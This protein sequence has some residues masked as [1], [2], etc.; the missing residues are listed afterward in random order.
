MHPIDADVSRPPIRLRPPPLAN[1]YLSGPRRLKSHSAFPIVTTLSQ[2]IQMRPRHF[3]QTTELLL[4][5]LVIGAI[6]KLLVRRSAQRAMQPVDQRQQLRILPG[7]FAGKLAP[8][9]HLGFDLFAT[10]VHP[11]QSCGLRTA[12]TSH[13]LDVAAPEPSLVLLQFLKLNFPQGPIH[14]AVDLL[15]TSSFEFDFIDG[16]QKRLN[17]LQAQ[18]L[19]CLHSDGQFPACRI[20][21]SGSSCVRNSLPL[22]AHLP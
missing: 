11:H 8:P 18:F 22:Q 21:S 14:P 16:F 9:I 4:A 13:L 12:Q 7:V 10:E 5:E 6:Q 2:P 17:L 15:P 19:C 3:R 1:R 20:A